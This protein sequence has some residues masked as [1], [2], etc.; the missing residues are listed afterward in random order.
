MFFK[1]ILFI[2]SII[3]IVLKVSSA[4]EN[5]WSTS[6]PYNCRAKDIVINP[7]NR[8]N[9][10]IGTIEYGIYR[11]E[12]YGFYWDHIDSDSLASTQR[13]I[14]I[15]PHNPDTMFATTTRG[16][17][18]SINGGDDWERV[19][20]PAGNSYEIVGACIHPQWTNIM[21]VPGPFFSGI[22]Y[23]SVDG[24]DTWEQLSLVEVVAND[25][26]IDP[27]N[28][29]TVYAISHCAT[30]RRSLLKSEDLGNTWIN[31]HGDLDTTMY[32]H[33]FDIDYID[34]QVLYVCG[35]DATQ[36]D[37]CVF[38]SI[39][40]GET[41][42]NITPPGLPSDIVWE[43][44]IS[45]FDHNTVYIC[46]DANGLMK[47][48]DGGQTWEEKNEGINGRYTVSLAI[49]EVNNIM[50]ICLMFGGVYRS[51]DGGETWEKITK[52]ISHSE[53]F[54]I[55]CNP[56]YPDEIYT[57]SM[58][59]IYKIEPGQDE[60][61]VIDVLYPDYNRYVSC[62]DI[63]KE[64][65]DQIFA[66]LSSW[67]SI[68]PQTSIARSIDGGDTWDYFG[69]DF[70][71]STEFSRLKIGYFGDERKIF[72]SSS[73]GLYI[74]DDYGENWDLIN[75]IPQQ[76]Y[77]A[78]D[79]SPS[80]NN[81]IYIGMNQ[82]YKSTD[83]GYFWEQIELP[84]GGNYINEIKCHPYDSLKVYIAIYGSGIYKSEDGGDSWINI[85][86]NIPYT[87]FYIWFSGI[88]INPL[89]T[90]NIY[91]NSNHYSVF[92]SHND[93][94]S[95]EPFSDSLIVSYSNGITLIDPSD[96][97]KIYVATDQQSV[98]SITRTPAGIDDNEV[99][100]LPTQY[101]LSAYPNPFNATTSI[102]F[103]LIQPSQVT[104]DIYDILGRRAESLVDWYLPAGN[105]SV[106]W[107]AGEMP[108]GIYF[109]RLA[110][111]D[112]QDSRKITL[113]K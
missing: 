89:N 69:D 79:I 97:N 96:T 80:N 95:W 103:T 41:W 62:I 101:D 16:M 4:G 33:G 30:T 102:S 99:T 42:Q 78:L 63:D 8:S 67:W 92:Q 85:T 21:F 2:A 59:G 17:F 66:G 109:Y 18:K 112:Y 100:T 50:Y 3:I 54:D 72:A 87:D 36:S 6:G 111:G 82:M 28:D 84:S 104:L 35:H 73:D 94:D 11:T 68:S 40:G 91:V 108:S 9:I 15:N 37:R 64:Y 43:I 32:V 75:E 105:H 47:S 93:G 48:T 1:K 13:E 20:F 25:F 70:N 86:N 98:W 7:V 45:P 77:F 65:P 83:G 12:N 61:E 107:Q 113:L 76:A 34:N 57:C 31:S 26:K 49:D 52:E 38:K 51:Y 22:N 71:E 81:Y 19:D 55:V 60:W 46:T 10:F 27:L 14:I 29:S 23:R 106:L 44:D 88:A 39:N 5:F 24:G 56:E 74:S 53:C 110:A 58:N 90:D